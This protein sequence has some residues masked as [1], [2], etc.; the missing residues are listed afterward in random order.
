MID[1]HTHIY[2]SEFENEGENAYTRALQAGVEK[3]ILPNVDLTSV[4]PLIKLYE[5][6]PDRLRTAFGLHPTSVDADWRN[7]LDKIVPLI[8]S[9]G[10]V[11]VGEIGMDLYW[12][13]T[14]KSQQMEA[15]DVQLDMA[16]KRKLPVI[17]HC[18]EALDETLNVIA[19]GGFGSMPLLFHSFTGSTDDAE[20]ILA[21]APNALFGING[22][23][24]FKNARNLHAAI[25]KIG[26][27][28]IVLETDSPYLA[29]V[30]HRGK[31]NESAYISFV[32]DKVAELTDTTP[33]ETEAATDRNARK[34]FHL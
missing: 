28:K 3:M 33:S 23:V 25:P 6:H 27:E 17:I 26:L 16:A 31:R 20:R 14:F 22:V 7:T 9:P 34:L 18:R 8:D 1:T 19:S 32:R 10:C 21:V 29:P 15:F 2:L 24:T 12:D 5:N 30:P 4:R 13:T 11:A